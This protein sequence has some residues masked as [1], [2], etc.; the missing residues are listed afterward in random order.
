MSVLGRKTNGQVDQTVH[1]E[2]GWSFEEGGGLWIAGNGFGL[3][4]D[5]KGFWIARRALDCREREEGFGL[6]GM[7]LDCREGFGPLF[8]FSLEVSL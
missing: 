6:Q 8:G 3:Q 2:R 1:I 4:R 7:G 5:G